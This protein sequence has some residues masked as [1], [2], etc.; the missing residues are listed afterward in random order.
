MGIKI[1]NHIRIIDKK[2]KDNITYIKEKQIEKI[3]ASNPL[4]DELEKRTRKNIKEYKSPLLSYSPKDDYEWLANEINSHIS[5]F[6]RDYNLEN[7]YKGI[8]QEEEHYRIKLNNDYFFHIVRAVNSDNKIILESDIPL[9]FSISNSPGMNTSDLQWRTDDPV[10]FFTKYKET[11]FTPL[12]KT[13]IPSL[14]LKSLDAKSLF[15]MAKI[16]SSYGEYFTKEET[17]KML[18]RIL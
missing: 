3:A 6:V 1:T 16:V 2:K 14:D 7:Q 18:S 11:S 10:L 17:D 12:I 5:D 15:Y 9:G 8:R 13:K 4:I